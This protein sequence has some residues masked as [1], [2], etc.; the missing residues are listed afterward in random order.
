[1]IA[2]YSQTVRSF[3]LLWAQRRDYHLASNSF[4]CPLH[5]VDLALMAA[6]LIGHNVSPVAN[7]ILVTRT[8]SILVIL[9]AYISFICPFESRYLLLR[10]APSIFFRILILFAGSY[11][12]VIFQKNWP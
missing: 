10:S 7:L 9:T 6:H 8:I 1:M 12:E 2:T 5:L 4:N 11:E 3:I